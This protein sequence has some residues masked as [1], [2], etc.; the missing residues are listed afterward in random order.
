MMTRNSFDRFL[1]VSLALVVVGLV[2]VVATAPRRSAQAD[3]QA[4]DRA[5]ERTL[6][7]QAR[8][9][10]I[11]ELYGPVEALRQTGQSQSALLKL[12]EIEKSYPGEAHGQIL[13]GEI[14]AQLGALDEA[15]ASYAAAV[16]LSGDYVERDSPLSQRDE[17]QQLVNDGLKRV[18]ARL[19]EH[20][21]NRSAQGTMKQ[22]YYLQSRLA[23]G[24]E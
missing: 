17:I 10:L 15:V 21:D 7:Y 6:A 19:A 2:L 8:V 1:W 9:A 20:P 4:L 11:K 23:G 5:L 12:A 24:C 3:G 13:K 16:R 22:L 18:G 14:Q